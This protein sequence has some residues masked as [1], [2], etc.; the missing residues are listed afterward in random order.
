M[1]QSTQSRNLAIILRV[2]ISRYQIST[3]QGSTLQPFTTKT[4][5]LSLKPLRFTKNEAKYVKM[6]TEVMLL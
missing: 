2:R 4:V 5:R 1:D 3:A 6:K